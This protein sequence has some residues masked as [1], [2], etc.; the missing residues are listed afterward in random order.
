[1][2]GDKLCYFSARTGVLILFRTYYNA[3]HPNIFHYRQHGSSQNIAIDTEIGLERHM[4]NILP[5]IENLKKT[6][7]CCARTRC[8]K[9]FFLNYLQCGAEKFGYLRKA[10]FKA[11]KTMF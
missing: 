4:T 5:G 11:L 9:L 8:N 2:P 7:N 6:P 10:V 3:L 1:M